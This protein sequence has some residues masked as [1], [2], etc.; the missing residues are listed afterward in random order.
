LRMPLSIIYL[1]IHSY[2]IYPRSHSE[3]KFI[4]SLF[5]LVPIQNLLSN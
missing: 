2:H 3:L 5:E 4:F 1:V